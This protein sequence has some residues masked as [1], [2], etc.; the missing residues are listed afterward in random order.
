MK[1]DWS[2]VGERSREWGYIMDNN[3]EWCFIRP[4]WEILMGAWI[5]KA[6]FG[7]IADES[8]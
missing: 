2:N 3:L 4:I 1:I 5:I 8:T 7:Q 6:F